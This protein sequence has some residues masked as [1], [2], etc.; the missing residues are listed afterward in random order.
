MQ[1]QIT[2]YGSVCSGIEAATVAWHGLGWKPAWFSEIEPFP[3]AV[4]A[5]RYPDIENLG[6]M[7]VIDELVDF[8]MVYAPYVLVGG[9]PCQAFSVAGLRGGLSDHRGQL[10]LSY[11][12]LA[13]AIDRRRISSGKQPSI[14]VWENVPGVLSSKDNA[15]GCFLAGLAG[16]DCELQPSG[17]KWPNAGYV[18]GPQR[19][20]AWRILDAQ[21]F[22]VAQRRRRVFVVASARDGFDP[23]AVLFE[24]DGL[25]RDTASR[26]ETRESITH[27][28]APCLTS[29]GRR[30]ERTGD[31][32]GQ[33]PVVAVIKQTDYILE[34]T[35]FAKKQNES[36]IVCAVRMVAFGEYVDDGSSSTVKARD[37]KDATDLVVVHGTQDP[38]ISRDTSSAL[39]GAGGRHEGVIVPIAWSGDITPKYSLD[40]ATTAM[41]AQQGG[42][43]YGVCTQHAQVRRLTPTECERLQG[44]PD[45]YTDIPKNVVRQKI[46]GECAK[47]LVVAT[48]VATNG[49]HYVGYNAVDTP[50]PECPRGNMATGEGY[51]LCKDV[52]RQTGHAEINA[53]KLAGKYA[54]GATLYIEGHTYACRECAEFAN[55]NAIARIIIG[56]PPGTA[57]DGPR[58]KAL[59]NSMA[60]PVMAWIGQRI[61]AALKQK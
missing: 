27:A 52:C 7:T 26:R 28:T 33:D 58:Y 18:L 47:Q 15:F 43:G 29:S 54:K 37:Y 14:I 34:E 17:K 3:S 55:K 11:V 53:I 25:R 40:C 24:F 23:A 41:R 20:V 6:D 1:D 39:G 16:E 5:H 32:R 30:V 35:L 38:C 13:N 2:T 21:Y 50:Q 44:F 31:T 46:V 59:G 48:V 12:E 57:A 51:H 10:T 22:G 45:S 61:D 36:E 19:A 8:D 9:T 56:S 60:V 4:L 42:E 49:T